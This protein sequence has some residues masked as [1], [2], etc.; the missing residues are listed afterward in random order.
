MGP[1]L[2]LYYLYYYNS[3]L[4]YAFNIR[5]LNIEAKFG[6]NNWAPSQETTSRGGGGSPYQGTY[7]HLKGYQPVKAPHDTHPHHLAL[8]RAL[9]PL[10]GALKP[11]SH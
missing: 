1:T 3:D 6:S 8:H 4:N 10:R 9:T 2:S 11:H 5:G 7:Q